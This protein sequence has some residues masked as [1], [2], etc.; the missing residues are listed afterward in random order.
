MSDILQSNNIPATPDENGTTKKRKKP[1]PKTNYTEAA[2][3]LE[4]PATLLLLATM[5]AESQ[6][7]SRVA[8]IR[9]A[10]QEVNR[11]IFVAGVMTKP[12]TWAATKYQSPAAILQEAKSLGVDNW[13]RTV[14]LTVT[15]R[16]SATR[17]PACVAR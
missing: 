11:A 16:R 9:R 5:T 17:L 6:N 10:I 3:S 7:I 12:T 13:D 1:G 4:L 14:G 2:I 15:C 8:F